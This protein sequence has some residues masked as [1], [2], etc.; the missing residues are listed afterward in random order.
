MSTQLLACNGG[1]WH[2]SEIIGRNCTTLTENYDISDVSRLELLLPVA[3]AGGKRADGEAGL[4]AGHQD[5]HRD[6]THRVWQ[7]S[8]CLHTARVQVSVYWLTCIIQ[9]QY[10][11]STLLYGQYWATQQLRWCNPTCTTV[12]CSQTNLVHFNRSMKLLLK[13]N[14]DTHVAPSSEALAN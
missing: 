10:S 14:E 3:C 8:V 9:L 2:W 12:L 6:A 1:N 4:G 11:Y 7:C 5:A 13:L